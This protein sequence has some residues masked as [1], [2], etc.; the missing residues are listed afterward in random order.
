MQYKFQGHLLQ[1]ASLISLPGLGQVALP[2]GPTMPL[3][4]S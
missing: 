1:E 3:M 2:G 4:T